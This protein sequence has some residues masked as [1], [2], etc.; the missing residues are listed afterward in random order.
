MVDGHPERF[1]ETQVDQVDPGQAMQE[2]ADWVK[3][4]G[5]DPIFMAWPAHFD[6]VWVDLY[7]SLYEV[8]NPFSYKPLDQISYI[9]GTQKKPTIVKGSR[10]KGTLNIPL[11]WEQEAALVHNAL[12]DAIAQRNGFVQTLKDTNNP[13]A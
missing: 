1:Q 2:F 5:A 9:A 13:G 3:S 6:F 11:T 4:L 8:E 12:A 10:S 7:F